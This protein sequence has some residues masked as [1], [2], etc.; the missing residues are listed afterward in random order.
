MAPQASVPFQGLVTPL[1]CVQCWL[2][3]GTLQ[4]EAQSLI[5]WN[6][7]STQE[8]KEGDECSEETNIV[9]EWG[10]ERR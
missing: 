7:E 6:L 3:A 2:N 1:L 9:L 10:L 5:L 4:S 8:D